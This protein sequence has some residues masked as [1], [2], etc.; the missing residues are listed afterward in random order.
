M[1]DCE[2]VLHRV[3]H[4]GA[5]QSGSLRWKKQNSRLYILFSKKMRPCQNSCADYSCVLKRD[6]APRRTKGG[7]GLCK[8]TGY[9][10]WV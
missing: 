8:A 10:Y 6:Y 4:N 2:L 3:P 1:N 7:G 5:R 9:Y